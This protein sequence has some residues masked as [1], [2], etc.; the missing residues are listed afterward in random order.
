LL[1]KDNIYSWLFKN[2]HHVVLALFLIL[3]SR[4]RAP[5]PTFLYEAFFGT[6][7]STLRTDGIG[8]QGHVL[9]VYSKQRHFFIEIVFVSQ[10]NL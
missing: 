1:W 10:I 3:L 5:L 9:G 6:T 4:V 7:T 2:L 8:K